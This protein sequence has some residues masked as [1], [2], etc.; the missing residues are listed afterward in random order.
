[1]AGGYTAGQLQVFQNGVQLVVGTDVTASNGTTFV[2]TNAANSG[3]T[4]VAISY[5]SFIAANAV[6]KSGD[7]MSGDLTVPNFTYTGTLTGSTGVVNIGS[8]QVYKDASGNVGIGTSAPTVIGAG[9]VTTCVNGSTQGTIQCMSGGTAR[10]TMFGN[11]SDSG[12]GTVTATPLKIL[13]NAAEAARIDTS[14]NLLV[15]TTS[16]WAGSKFEV[17]TA[18]NTWGISGYNNNTSGYGAFIA[19]TD[20]TAAN[21]MAFYYGASTQVGL[22]TTNGTNTTYGTSSDQRLKENIVNAPSAASV[23]ENIKIRS[24]DWKS[25]GSHQ[26][27]GVIAQEL[28]PLAPDAVQVPS[29]P[30]TM[31]GVDYSKLVPALIK[32]VQELK[33]EIDALKGAK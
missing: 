23:I 19:R 17:K 7:T 12:I 2:L 26:D 13:T 11:S 25:N 27:F 22:I 31:M 6:A 14:G 21:L 3:D 32:Y 28:L 8:G 1:V 4:L 10:L 33:A 15:N 30:E 24:F 5:S 18:T 9:Y 16:S 20:N 29:N